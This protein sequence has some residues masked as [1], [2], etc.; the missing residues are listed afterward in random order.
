[1]AMG[2]VIARLAVNLSLDTVAF[3]KGATS[4]EK[5]MNQ[6]KRK[7]SDLGKKI[8]VGAAAIGASVVAIGVKFRDMAQQAIQ[9][10]KEIEEFA[11]ISNAGVEEFQ[12]AAFAARSVGIESDKLADIY[13]DVNDRIGDF[14]ATGGGPMAD[15]F[16]N[17]APKVGVTAE[18]FEKLSGPQALQLFVS[19]LEKAGLS[20]QQMTFY[21]EAMA[22][23]AT[24]LIPLMRENGKAMGAFAEEAERLGLVMSSEEIAKAKEVAN[25]LALLNAQVDAKQNKKMLEHADSILKFEEGLST[26]KLA[27]IDAVVNVQALG[28]AMDRGTQATHE[29]LVSMKNTAL[30]ALTSTGQYFDNL[31]LSANAALRRLY[32]SVKT[33]LQDK[34]NAVW[35]WV[36]KKVDWVANKFKWLD[37]VVVRNSYI[38]DMVESIG[39]HMRR[40]DGL[41][42]DPATKATEKTGEAFRNLASDIRSILDRLFPEAARIRKMYEEIAKLEAGMK[43]GP[44]GEAPLLTEDV[45]LA[46]IAAARA[47]ARGTGRAE[48]TAGT[49][50]APAG[51]DIEATERRL[52]KFSDITKDVADKTKVS[53]VRIAESFKDMAEKTLQSVRGLVDAIKG[54]GFLDILESA[55]GLFMNLAGSGVFGKGLAGKVNSVPGYATGTNSAA[56]GW[57]WV[58]ERGPELVKFNGGERVLNNSDSMKASGGRQRVEIIPSPYFDVVVDGRV[59]R[60][61]PAIAQGGAQ[62]AGQQMQFQ[63]SRRLA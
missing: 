59:Q 36:G 10:A 23:D 37:D 60:A 30:N 19:S 20:Q 43:R 55:V 45:G 18:Q 57:A 50:A 28:A 46:A 26:L 32:I 49:V 3:E 51:L 31:A 42:V 29:A 38:P 40:L 44:N 9:S 2:D 52:G 58:G 41:M 15:F 22:S 62:L 63:R 13:K 1:M 21:M 39:D 53:T 8:A 61:A 12:K 47:D 27:L 4:S 35:D 5:R 11:Q 54:G 7:F 48:P 17:I 25:N 56:R 14:I 16:E 33:W 6:M 24:L 34:L